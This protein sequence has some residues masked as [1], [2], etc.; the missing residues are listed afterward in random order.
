MKTRAPELSALI[1]ILRSTGPVISTRRSRRSAGGGCDLPVVLGARARSPAARRRPAPP[2]ARAAARAARAGSG[3]A[4]DGAARRSSSASGERTSASPGREARA[5]SMPGE[6]RFLGRARERERR[7]LAET[8]GA[9]RRS[10]RRRP[11][12][13]GGSPCSR[14]SSSVELALLELDV[15]RHAALARSRRRARTSTRS[16]RGSRRA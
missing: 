16:G 6:L 7:A 5:C 10:S 14:R 8:P 2:A 15:R 9:R 3:S 11:R 13:G 12:A 1:I 4:R